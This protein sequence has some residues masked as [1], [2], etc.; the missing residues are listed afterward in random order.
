[1]LK[2]IKNR[3]IFFDPPEVCAPNLSGIGHNEFV[4]KALKEIGDKVVIAI[5]FYLK[6]SEVINGDVYNAIKKH[7]LGW[8]E[9]LQIKMVDL[10]FLHRINDVE[11]CKIFIKSRFIN[12]NFFH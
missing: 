10:Y 12:N 11:I 9:R 7:I 4:G 1:M 3:C 2:W 5:K 6:S 8:M